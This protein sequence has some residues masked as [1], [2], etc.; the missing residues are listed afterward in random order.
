MKPTVLVVTTVHWPD[1]T[2]IRERLIRTLATTFEVR[3]ASREPGPTDTSDLQWVP[4]R[5]RRVRRNLSALGHCLFTDWDV[6]VVHDAELLPAAMLARLLRR[7]SVA[8]DVHENIPATAMTR[9][10]VPGA[11][12]RPLASLANALLRLAE[13]TLAIT[14]AEP[15][16]ETLFTRSHVVFPNHPETSRYPE[17]VEGDGSVVYLG[18]VTVERGAEVAADA[19]AIHGRPMKFVGRVDD[20]L[21]SRLRSRTRSADLQF[22]GRLPNPDGLAAIR[23]A[24]VAIAPL[25][26]TPNYRESAPTKILE[27][28]A[29]GL[30]VV[31][32]DLP[33]TR[34]LVEGLEAVELVPPGDHR[35]LA[36]AIDRS[37]DPEIRAIAARQ[38]DEVRERYRWPAE[39]VAAFYRSLV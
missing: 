18:D 33:G 14:L 38:A 2:R 30:P 24:G 9:D 32:S 34:R 12:R 22:S 5:G 35:A 27:Y 21:Q 31:A 29:L 28:L 36:G 13:R 19:A 1:D 6:L 20:H 16:Y 7:R 15:E 37:A 11:L 3:Y 25:L 17:P 8:F 26:D 4:L 39:E 10:W 23:T